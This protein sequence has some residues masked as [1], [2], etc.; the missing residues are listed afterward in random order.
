MPL[1]NHGL[2][3]LLVQLRL[4]SAIRHLVSKSVTFPRIRLVVLLIGFEVDR[5]SFRLL[6]CLNNKCP[7]CDLLDVWR[8]LLSPID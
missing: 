6:P 3:H 7:I 1:R 4:A 5:I 2:N 8:R